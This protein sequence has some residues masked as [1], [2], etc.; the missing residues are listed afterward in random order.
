MGEGREPIYPS[1]GDDIIRLP[2]EMV[3]SSTDR[4]EL[5][6]EIFG[7][8]PPMLHNVDFMS[9]R[10]ILGARNV[11]VDTINDLATGKFPG[12]VCLEPL[13]LKLPN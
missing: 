13:P 8:D 4:E 2:D 12:E 3:S 7:S 9:C 11:D 5:I 10:A 1:L 6:T